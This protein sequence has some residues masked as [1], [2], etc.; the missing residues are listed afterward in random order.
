MYTPVLRTIEIH[1]EVWNL[2]YAEGE[3]RHS[4]VGVN[5]IHFSDNA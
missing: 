4:L 5:F 3:T 2:K 1:S